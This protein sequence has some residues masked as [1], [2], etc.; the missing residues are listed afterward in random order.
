MNGVLQNLQHL[1]SNGMEFST[2]R[3]RIV[4]NKGFFFCT[5]SH[6]KVHQK[7]TFFE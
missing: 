6:L 3:I 5:C 4:C 2:V 1:I 7:K